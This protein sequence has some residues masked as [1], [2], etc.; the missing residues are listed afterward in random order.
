MTETNFTAADLAPLADH[1]GCEPH[2]VSD[3]VADYA[4]DFFDDDFQ[5]ALDYLL[6]NL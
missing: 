4:S 6:E 5:A 2:E 1:F 3:C